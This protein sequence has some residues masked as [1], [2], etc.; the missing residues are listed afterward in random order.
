MFTPEQSQVHSLSILNLMYGYDDFMESIRTVIDLGC[1]A[2][3]DAEWWVTRT[4]NDDNPEPLNIRCVGIDYNLNFSLLKRHP[5]LTYEKADFEEPIDTQKEKTFDVLWCH[6]SFQYC[7]NPLKTLSTWRNIAS[8]DSMLVISLPQTTNIKRR[9]LSAEQ[10]TGSY[11]HHSIVSLIHML[12][13]TGWDCRNGFFLKQP[14]DLWINAIVYNS[15]HAPMDPKT[16][17][18]HELVEKKLLPDC[19]EPSIYAHNKLRQEDLVLPWL[20]K[21]LNW[22]GKQ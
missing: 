12:S 14:N 13:V 1:G 2:G 22:L 3:H 18:W 15:T 21:S 7:I 10:E 19:A 17:S 20:D 11:Y 9:L 5:N 4:T 16:T 8:P 6:N